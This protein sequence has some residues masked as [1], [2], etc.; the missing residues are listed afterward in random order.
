MKKHEKEESG[1]QL[2]A[3]QNILATD[4]RLSQPEDVHSH[5]LNVFNDR[6]FGS[7]LWF[8]MENAFLTSPYSRSDGSFPVMVAHFFRRHDIFT[9][10]I[11]VSTK[12]TRFDPNQY[13]ALYLMKP[14]IMLHKPEFVKEKLGH[15]H[16]SSQLWLISPGE[17]V[18]LLPINPLILD[19]YGKLVDSSDMTET[20]FGQSEKIGWPDSRNIVVVVDVGSFIMKLRSAFISPSSSRRSRLIL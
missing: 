18:E 8:I 7:A 6:L 10:R 1:A 5:F 13:E 19:N 11:R 20:I 3:R 15:S 12:I 17:K 4:L 14:I 16:I 2:L 9:D